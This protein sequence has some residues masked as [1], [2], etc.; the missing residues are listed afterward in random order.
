[1]YGEGWDYSVTDNHE[2][3]WRHSYIVAKSI[4]DFASQ[5]LHLGLLVLIQLP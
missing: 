1:M 5:T 4:K 3:P 2:R